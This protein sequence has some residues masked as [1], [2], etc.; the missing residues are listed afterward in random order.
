[1]L[2]GVSA[3]DACLF[4]V[5]ATEGWKEQS[6]EHLRILELLGIARGVVALT[7]VGLVDDELRELAALEIGD[8]LRGTFLDGAEIVPVDVPAGIGSTPSAPPSTAW[9]QPLHQPRTGAGPACGSTG[10]LRSGAPDRSSRA[11][12]PAVS[13]PSTTSW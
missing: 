4:V 10:P 1:M 2:A 7:K 6:E 13:W 9:S 5:A 12:W 8:R 3:V 11:R